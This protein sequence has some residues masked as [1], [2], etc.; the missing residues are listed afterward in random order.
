MKRYMLLAAAIAALVAPT[1]GRADADAPGAETASGVT[2]H[3][4]S[5][6]DARRYREIFADE[7]EGQF[8]EG[9]ELIEGISDRSLMGYVEAAHYLSP[10]LKK[11]AVADLAKWL[12]EYAELPVAERIRGLAEE[13]ERH[14]RHKVA[15]AGIPGIP[16]RAVGS[17][18]STD[19]VA[20][21]PLVSDAS[22]LAQLS[23]D[24]DV[25]VDQPSAAEAVLQQLVAQNVAP[26]SDIARL[27]DRVAASYLA[28]GQ[29]E[30]AYRVS[31]SVTGYDRN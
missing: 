15:L 6:E 29:D 9:R 18:E 4:L 13:R 3:V 31:A 20:N 8:A 16:R 30:D 26:P 2:P 27:T 24:G 21:P 1:V 7:A 28:E 23:I 25:K 5:A 10:Y 11:P 17:Y 22:R 19:N 14:R 12:D